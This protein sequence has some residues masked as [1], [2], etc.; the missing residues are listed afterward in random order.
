[1]FVILQH[2]YSTIH[3]TKCRFLAVKS[4]FTTKIGVSWIM[5]LIIA[6]RHSSKNSN[7][8]LTTIND[9]KIQKSEGLVATMCTV[10]LMSQLKRGDGRAKK[11]GRRR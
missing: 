7:Y 5:E 2:S 10:E 6:D 8:V 1:M 11:P 9:S 4:I 3:T